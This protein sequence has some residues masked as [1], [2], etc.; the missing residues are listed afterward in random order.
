MSTLDFHA[1]RSKKGEPMREKKIIKAMN[2]I[3]RVKAQVEVILAEWPNEE[4]VAYHLTD[5]LEHLEEARSAFELLR[6]EAV[7]GVKHL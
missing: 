6:K 1:K 3:E 2:E 4:G 5:C 7:A